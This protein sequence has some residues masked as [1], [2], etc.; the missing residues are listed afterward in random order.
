MQPI[1][2]RDVLVV[3][4]D[5]DLKDLL[6]TILHPR[7]W[8]I[9]YVTTNR[10][11]LRATKDKTFE[12]IITSEKTSGREDIE[13]LRAI[14]RARPHTRLII[15]AEESTPDDVLAAMRNHAF[16]F[17]SKPYSLQRLGEMIQF[18]TETPS[19]DD[20]IELKSATP[21]WIQLEV[22]CQI[23]TAERLLQFMKEIVEL[24]DTELE[25]VGLAFREILLNAMEHG[26]RF[27]PNAYVQVEYVR[28][29]RMVSCRISDP[30]PGFTL[31]EIPHAAVANPLD[32]PVRHAA[33][34]DEMGLRP[35]G[36]GI[37]LAQNL[38]DQVIYGQ[39]G[40]EV[41]LIK[42][43]PQTTALRAIDSRGAA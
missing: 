2:V 23:R 18:A 24:P 40:N 19:W 33:V 11:A 34:R 10:A 16:S 39:H 43:L 37:L 27:D 17:F 14:R 42:Y 31:D 26:G 21:E 28:A 25:E 1:P 20:G 5:Q 3:D 22:R 38:V 6:V 8:A 7:I 9:R 30:G 41:L 13:L 35:G 4:A 32:D 15:L 12:L 36:L 29:R